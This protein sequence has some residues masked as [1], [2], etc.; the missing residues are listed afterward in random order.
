MNVDRPTVNGAHSTN[1]DP[2]SAA[3]GPSSAGP[4]KQTPLPQNPPHPPLPSSSNHIPNATNGDVMSSQP[5]S[6]G[7]VGNNVSG[8][9]DH[10]PTE[11]LQ[12]ISQDSYLPL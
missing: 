9:N 11:I 1:G 6:A 4:V 3:A 5:P 2:Q 10:P 12:L 7:G 8:G